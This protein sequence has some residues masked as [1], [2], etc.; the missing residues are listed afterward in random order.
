VELWEAR[1]ADS[2]HRHGLANEEIRHALR[3]LIAVASD[4]EDDGVTLF[5]GPDR[6]ANLIEVAVLTTEDGPLIVH[7]MAAR[8]HRFQ[9]PEE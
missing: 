1:V 2:A 4:P 5:L 3:N 6:A 9:P 8:I 7:A